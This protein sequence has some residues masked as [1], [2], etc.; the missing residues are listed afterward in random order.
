MKILKNIGLII[1]GIILALI[2]SFN[3][4]EF[5]FRLFPSYGFFG[6]GGDAFNYLIGLPIAYLFFLFLLFTAFGDQH[7]KWWIGIASIPALAFLLYFD[8]SHIYFHI[9]FPLAG[10]LIGCGIHKLLAK[11]QT[12]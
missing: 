1:V 3:L 7:K 12:L 2:P 11:P 10:W 9:L 8:F 6:F 5:Y 4:G